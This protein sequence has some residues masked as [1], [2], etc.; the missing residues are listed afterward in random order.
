L[1]IDIKVADYQSILDKYAGGEKGGLKED[2]IKKLAAIEIDDAFANKTVVTKDKRRLEQLSGY[3]V[4]EL[5]R[6]LDDCVKEIIDKG[7][8]YKEVIVKDLRRNRV[9]NTQANR[10]VDGFYLL[11]NLKEFLH[12][13]DDSKNNPASEGQFYKLLLQAFGGLDCS[14][15]SIEQ[16]LPNIIKPVMVSRLAASSPYLA[17]NPKQFPS[18][19]DS[20][21]NALGL[22]ELLQRKDWTN[23]PSKDVLAYYAVTLGRYD[24]V[25]FTNTKLPC[26][27]Q[28][29]RF[30]HNDQNEQSGSDEKEAFATHFAR[31]EIAFLL[32]LYNDCEFASEQHTL[33]AISS[34]SL[35]RRSMRLN[36]VY[37]LLNARKIDE[38]ESNYEFVESGIEAKLNKLI[39][40]FRSPDK[41]SLVIK[42]LLTDGW[43]DL[44]LVFMCRE[45]VEKG[46][47]HG[48]IM[49]LQQALYEDFMVD[50]TELIYTP[51]CLDHMNYRAGYKFNFA[52]RFQ[53]DRKLER[54]IQNF[55]EALIKKEESFPL[56][57]K[58]EA[59]KINYKS[60][61]EIAFTTGQ[62][63]VRV[64]IRIDSN[65]DVED[66]YEKLLSWF[67]ETE[68]GEDKNNIYNEWYDD[69]LA[70]IDKIETTIERIQ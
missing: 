61:F 55:V 64:S 65:D 58:W 11:G 42:A 50:R 69:G 27:C 15:S 56:P 48:D 32:K 5:K 16:E 22:A 45:G 18:D 1:V 25:S 26:L 24:I 33:F 62:N 21:I 37:R 34:I 40:N 23:K 49:D 47:L 29:S 66:I 35:Q 44:L 60:S 14:K 67:A 53:E 6:I 57:V 20:N 12:I 54:S 13:R 10:L 31:R 30:E 7:E 3:K 9:D 63:D 52:F 2:E 17:T 36:L 38:E 4:K 59:E 46:S 68:I 19:N 43:G 39:Q 51:Q 70:F 28:V 8:G 41:N